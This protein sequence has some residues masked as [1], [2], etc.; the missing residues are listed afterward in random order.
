MFSCADWVCVCRHHTNPVG[1]SWRWKMDDP[2][3]I[4]DGAMQNH[5]DMI[6]QFRGVPCCCARVRGLF[7]CT[8]C[9]LS[10]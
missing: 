9:G 3:M 8:S 6:K 4:I 10:F 1:T 5:Y 2:K 7:V